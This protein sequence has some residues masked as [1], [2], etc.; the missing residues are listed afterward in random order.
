MT[1]NDK[2]TNG[3]RRNGEGSI[4]QRAS[5]GLWVGSAYVV[6][7]SGQ[8][9]RKPVYGHS[10][11]DVHAKL[12][13]MLER[14]Q[15]GIP[16]PERSCTVGQYFDYWLGEVVTEK[17]RKTNS[18]YSDTVRLHIRPVLEKKKLEKLSVMD[19]R[20][21]LAVVRTKC[22]CCTNK[23]DKS[24]EDKCCSVGKCCKRYP[25]K[26]TVQSVHSVLRNALNSAMRDELLMRNVAELVK[27]PAPRYRAGKG[28]PVPVV[29]RILD[30]VKDHRYYIAYV[31]AATMGLRRGELLGLRWS[32]LDLDEGLLK[33]SQTNPPATST[34]PTQTTAPSLSSMTSY[35]PVW[36]GTPPQ[37]PSSPTVPLP[38]LVNNVKQHVM[39]C[40]Q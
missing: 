22:L 31:L 8:R 28:L 14:S 17:R 20:H 23:W 7:T 40:P 26:R 30:A 3:R 19:V 15:K 33:V 11:D 29:K 4:Y 25:S 36:A 13:S 12:V 32:D 35:S 10:F 9:K 37:T 2:K 34:R 38:A 18:V 24:K 6:T 27:V 5:D 39:N 16:I 21:L 1:N